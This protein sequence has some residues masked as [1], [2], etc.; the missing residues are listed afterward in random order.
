MSDL[1][2]GEMTPEERTKANAK[3]DMRYPSGTAELR[4]NVSIHMGKARYDP[5]VNAVM[6][7]VEAYCA[8]LEREGAEH[9]LRVLR[10]EEGRMRQVANTVY[11]VSQTIEEL[12][13]VKAMQEGESY[14]EYF[15]RLPEET[16]Q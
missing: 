7:T 9:A 11:Y 3:A 15:K 13:G 12:G 6:A 5:A 10:S 4:K 8:G 1:V 16:E 2:A 14:K